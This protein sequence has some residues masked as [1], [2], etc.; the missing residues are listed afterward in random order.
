[1]RPFFELGSEQIAGKKA[2]DALKKK[3]KKDHNREKEH[4]E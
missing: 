2:F 4:R 3:K 1:L